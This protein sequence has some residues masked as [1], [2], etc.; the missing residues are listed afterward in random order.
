MH[1]HAYIE[2]NSLNIYCSE[3]RFV[4]K[5]HREIRQ[6]T[7][8]KISSYAQLLRSVQ[9]LGLIFHE[10]CFCSASSRPLISCVAVWKQLHLNQWL[11]NKRRK[12]SWKSSLFLDV[13]E[14]IK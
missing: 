2:R 3:K 10:E 5:F 13:F 9:F 6:F 7:P 1:F 11:T 8:S 14:I 4:R 12:Y